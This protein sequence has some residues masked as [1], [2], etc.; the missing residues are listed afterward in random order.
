MRNLIMIQCELT[1]AVCN[2]SNVSAVKIRL[3][4]DSKE[5]I[6][7]GLWLAPV[8]MTTCGSQA[9]SSKACFK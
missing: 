5:I 8:E 6:S 3:F 2:K 9:S 1:L 4:V 7:I